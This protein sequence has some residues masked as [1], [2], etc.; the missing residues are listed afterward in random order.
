MQR[1]LGVAQVNTVEVAW[2][3]TLDGGQVVGVPLGGL[4][5]PRAGPVWM[6]VILGQGRE[7]L[8]DDLDIHLTPRSR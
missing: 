1:V 7:E 3:L 2:N 8:A 4:W 6:V 5:T